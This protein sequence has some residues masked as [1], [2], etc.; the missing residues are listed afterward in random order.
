MSA[1]HLDLSRY[2][3][4][5]RRAL[6][7]N[8]RRAVRSLA[9]A[10]RPPERMTVSAWAEMFRR[11]PQGH[12]FEG[13][14]RNAVAPELVEIMDAL[15]PEDPTET[16]VIMKCAQS[17]GSAAAE[18]WV[19]Y[20]ADRCS[21]P[22]L[23]V[24]AT[25]DAA[26]DWAAEKLWPTIEATPALNPA[27]GGAVVPRKAKDGSATTTMRIKF[28]RGG[29]LLLAG[30]NSAATL[31]Q[32]TVRFAIEDDLDQFPDDLE[33]QGSPEAM[34]DARLQ[35]YR[36][37]GLA[38]RLKISTPTIRGASKIEAA[39][40]AGD[41]R[42]FYWQC[43]HCE[44]WFAPHENDL[45]FDADRP[46]RTT[47]TAP[48]CGAEIRESQKDALKAAGRWIATREIA[49]ERPPRVFAPGE[50]ARWDG[51]L[52]TSRI[53]SY[54]LT[55][56]ISSFLGWADLAGAL[57]AAKGDPT[58]EKTEIN[59]KAGRAYEV[60]GDAPPAEELERLRETDWGA[61]TV[62]AGAVL[63]S[64]AADVQ[65]DGIYVEK[66]GWGRLEKS[67]MLDAAFLPGATDVAHEGAWR[68]LDAYTERPNRFAG[69]LMVPTDVTLVDAGFNTDAVKAFCA[70]RPR[71][72]AT[73]GVDGW[74][75]PLFGD[76]VRVQR[77]EGRTQ[78][79]GAH[80]IGTYPAK[81]KFYGFL[82]ATL[83]AA[84]AAA[85]GETTE[86]T[87]GFCRFGREAGRAY[88]EQVTAEHCVI[89]IRNGQPVRVWDRKAGQENHWLD[90]RV[91]NIAAAD[92]MNVA[93]LTEGEW[94]A[95]EAQRLAR[96]APV[97]GDLLDVR[98]PIAATPSPAP[99]TRRPAASDYW[100]G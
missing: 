61:E 80:Q 21:S 77:K 72:L 81:L 74:V 22:M 39:Y 52:R 60:K 89:K 73:K 19:G 34:V 28:R 41:Q 18:N 12:P 42:Q 37:R 66:L 4:R 84:A 50:L 31:R 79:W 11:F 2:P 30:A 86:E 32:R 91:G 57:A 93:R 44:S 64:I 20:V 33:G 43:P 49:G 23:F 100:E 38:K 55:G 96:P 3:A 17:G 40:E 56:V 71:R 29:Y 13:A 70:R 15:T 69:G 46:E 26:K 68:L 99:R 78:A 75:K 95:L 63:I 59:L 25:R 47:L 24:Q 9:R 83:K 8:E 14:W 1:P 88:F 10:W 36:K 65:G 16:V 54:H 98:P 67:W 87:R 90:C 51:R 27:R 48:C 85:N 6:R 35:V 76:Q 58:R 92:F 5:V 53:K 7:S 62:P 97:Q 45:H 94:A 82:R